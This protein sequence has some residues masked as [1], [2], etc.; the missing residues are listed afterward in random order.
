MPLSMIKDNHKRAC[1]GNG[2]TIDEKV[3]TVESCI[4]IIKERSTAHPRLY[5]TR[6]EHGARF[7]KRKTHKS[8]TNKSF[9]KDS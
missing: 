3:V 5:Q 7:S 8:S 6:K 2:F 1:H 4:P 9:K